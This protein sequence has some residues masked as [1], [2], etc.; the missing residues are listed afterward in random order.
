MSLHARLDAP[1]QPSALPWTLQHDQLVVNTARDDAVFVIAP[2]GEIDMASV[3]TLRSALTRAERSGR[4][5]VVVDLGGVHFID[6]TGL[7]AL[8][9]AHRR[10]TESGTCRLVL[11]PGRPAVQRVFEVCGLESVFTFAGSGRS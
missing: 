8:L 6:S 1:P 4:P 5:E 3:A 9:S 2:E 11:L 10:M 7:Q